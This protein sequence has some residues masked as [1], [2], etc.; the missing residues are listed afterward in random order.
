MKVFHQ[1]HSME[2]CELEYIEEIFLT[3]IYFERYDIEKCISAL[4]LRLPFKYFVNQCII[5]K[6]FKKYDDILT[7][8]FTHSSEAEMRG[9]RCGPMWPAEV[10]LSDVPASASRTQPS[11]LSRRLFAACRSFTN[12][13]SLSVASHDE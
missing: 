9:S 7:T 10:G 4:N 2:K 1:N 8:L 3:K 5:S 13:S 12:K 11:V 6:L